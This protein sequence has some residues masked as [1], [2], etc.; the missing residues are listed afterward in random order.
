MRRFR[1]TIRSGIL[2]KVWEEWVWIGGYMRRYPW[3]ILLYGK[4]V[5]IDVFRYRIGAR[6]FA[7][8]GLDF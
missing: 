1:E 7:A 8:A 5:L 3:Q 4:R 6:F 2:R